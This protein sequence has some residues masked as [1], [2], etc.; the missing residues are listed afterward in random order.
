MNITYNLKVSLNDKLELYDVC[1]FV[2]GEVRMEKREYL[3]NPSFVNM[4]EMSVVSEISNNE[5]HVIF[6]IP[7]FMSGGELQDLIDSILEFKKNEQLGINS[8]VI[9]NF[10]KEKENNDM[11]L[12]STIEILTTNLTFEAMLPFLK[13]GFPVARTGWNGK[14]MYVVFQKGYPE[15]VSCNK[16]TAEAQGITEGDIIKINPYFQ[17][18]CVDG[19]YSMWVPSINDIL[20]EDWQILQF[21]K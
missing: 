2:N 17:I 7:G 8:T 16:Q 4:N 21:M 20:A 14:G 19:T 10:I 1:A 3:L 5:D 13:K 15:G 9:F 11:N 6:L 12:K 18:K